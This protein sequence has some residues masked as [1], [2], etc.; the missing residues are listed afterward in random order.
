MLEVR[1]VRLQGAVVFL[2][3]F[4]RYR[5]VTGSWLQSILFYG[6]HACYL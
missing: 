2:M 5:Y 4:S 6:L 1:R 3:K